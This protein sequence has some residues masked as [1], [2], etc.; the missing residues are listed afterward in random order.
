MIPIEA[1]GTGYQKE[2]E[3]NSTGTEMPK[4]VG[5]VGKTPASEACH[6]ALIEAVSKMRAVAT[7]YSI[8]TA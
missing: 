8:A 3:L 7:A 4:G 6:M 2:P 5:C 1:G